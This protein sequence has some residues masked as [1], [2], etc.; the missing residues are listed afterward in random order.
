MDDTSQLKEQLEKFLLQTVS[1][2]DTAKENFYRGL[3]LGLGAIFNSRYQVSS[4]REAGNG[5]FDICMIPF[6]K[7]LPGILMELKAGKDCTENQLSELAEA[8]L[9]RINTKKYYA[10]METWK[11]TSVLQYGIAF[12][13]KNA[14]IKGEERKL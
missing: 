1:F 8:A 6:N 5:R 12:F 4:N 9:L 14:C 13:G 10:D 2:H 11:V 7:R 3:I